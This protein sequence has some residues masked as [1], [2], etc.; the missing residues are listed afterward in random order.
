MRYGDYTVTG[1]AYS[2]VFVWLTSQ[3]V[4][5]CLISSCSLSIYAGLPVNGERNTVK[6]KIMR[7]WGIKPR[8]RRCN[9]PSLAKWKWNT[10]R[11]T[12]TL[13]L[14]KHANAC[15]SPSKSKPYS[16]RNAN[17]KAITCAPRLCLTLLFRRMM[18]S[19]ANAEH[20]FTWLNTNS[21]TR[22]SAPCSCISS[23]TMTIYKTA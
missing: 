9:A 23:I 4:H 10:S 2:S 17:G 14:S 18:E 11:Q 6:T 15:T 13:T 3:T 22:D 20:V 19:Y 5:M 16:W 8:T 1:L 12:L 21:H 7:M